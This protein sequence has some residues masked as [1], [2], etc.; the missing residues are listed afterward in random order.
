MESLTVEFRMKNG[1][2]M[3]SSPFRQRRLLACALALVAGSVFAETPAPG[4]YRCYEPP[5]YTVM[6]WFDLDARGISVHGD[7][8]QALRVDAV[9]GRLTLPRDALPPYRHGFYFPP[10]AA[11]G[12]AGRATI[13]LAARADV[14]PTQRVWARLPRCYL[15][16]H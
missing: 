9:S 6:A 14:R 2:V 13:V 5:G 4:R 16:T 7:A 3:P 15:T 11:G 10:G 8:P 1:R 12:D